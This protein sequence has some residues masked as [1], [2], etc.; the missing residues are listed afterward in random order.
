MDVSLFTSLIC[1]HFSFP[2]FLS[3]SHPPSVSFLRFGPPTAAA[4]KVLSPFFLP[5]F[6]P[7]HSQRHASVS[8][9]S[10][11]FDLCPFWPLFTT[12]ILCFTQISSS[13]LKLVAWDLKGCLFSCSLITGKHYL[14]RKCLCNLDIYY[15]TTYIL[16]DVRIKRLRCLIVSSIV[17]SRVTKGFFG[18]VITPQ[19]AEWTG[20]RFPGSLQKNWDDDSVK[21]SFYTAAWKRNHCIRGNRVLMQHEGIPLLAGHVQV[22]AS[23]SL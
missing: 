18:Y 9:P 11:T 1:A 10:I 14:C 2:P 4:G 20:E 6:L 7:L 8:V 17:Y 19:V 22:Q 23:G 3:V 12:G 15:Y 5:H 16:S 13:Y 21:A